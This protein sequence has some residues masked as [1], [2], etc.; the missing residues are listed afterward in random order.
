MS[1]QDEDEYYDD[2]D[3]FQDD[4]FEDPEEQELKNILM[5]HNRQL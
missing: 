3:D 4:E 2:E 5:E 1:Q